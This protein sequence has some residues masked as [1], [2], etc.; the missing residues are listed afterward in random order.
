MAQINQRK[1]MDVLRLIEKKFEV[2]MLD[3]LN[4]LTVKFHGPIDTPYE[5]GV[6]RV[7]V[8]LP[9]NY[10]FTPPRIAFLNKIYHPNIAERSG[11][12]C[13]NVINHEWSAL[14][15]LNMIFETFLPQLL[16]Y[17]NSLDPLNACAAALL[18]SKSSKYNSKVIQYVR[19][20]AT[21]N[22]MSTQSASDTSSL[23]DPEEVA[24]VSSKSDE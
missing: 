12:V 8:R 19:S 3:R 10:P 15:D 7:L 5:N 2:N 21:E 4:E 13:L 20:Y 16:V 14:Y 17:P 1:R 9:N 24:D 6:W 22:E 11:I 23:S 18:L